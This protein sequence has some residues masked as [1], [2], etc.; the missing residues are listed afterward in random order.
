MRP[1][2]IDQQ[3]THHALLPLMVNTGQIEISNP[4]E[5]EHFSQPWEL[6]VTRLDKK[7]FSHQKTY[8]ITPS[9][10]LYK[11]SFS[12]AIHMHGLTPDGMLAFS[13]PPQLGKQ[14]LILE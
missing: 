10:M 9:V 2:P 1:L 12:S 11:E 14:S 5:F 7:A 4:I 8:L 3:N 6:M 13:I